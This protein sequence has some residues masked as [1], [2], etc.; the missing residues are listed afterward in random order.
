MRAFR[1]IA[2]ISFLPFDEPP[3]DTSSLLQNGHL[4]T[5]IQ[6]IEHFADDIRYDR[7]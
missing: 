4:R 2:K 3:F 7:V 6:K 1:I 5:C